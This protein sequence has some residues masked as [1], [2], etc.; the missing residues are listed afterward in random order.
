VLF[1]LFNEPFGITWAQWKNGDSTWAGMDDL[2]AA[3]RSSGATNWVIANGLQWGNDVSGWLAN[4]PT[5]PANRLVA[6]AHVYSFNA[7]VSPTCWDTY[8]KPVAAAV[9]FLITEM[10]EDDCL[11]GFVGT[12]FAW[13]DANGGDGYTP[14]AFNSSYSCGGG[15]GLISDNAGSPTAYGAGVRQ[16]YLDHRV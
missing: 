2:I 8:Y 7:C 4:R 6:G 9:P 12:L 14:W 11:A 13:S 3:V 5:D 1:D 16:Y 15:P 10:G